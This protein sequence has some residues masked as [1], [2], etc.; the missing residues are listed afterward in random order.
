[1]G[2]ADHRAA[3]EVY[4]RAA[5]FDPERHVDPLRASARPTASSVGGARQVAGVFRGVVAGAAT[6]PSVDAP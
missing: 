5:A 3:A 6:R 4:R 1:M 2:K